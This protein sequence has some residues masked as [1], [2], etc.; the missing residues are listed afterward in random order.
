MRGFGRDCWINQQV[1]IGYHNRTDAPVLGDNVRVHAGAK[2]IGAVRVGDHAIIGA[3]AVVVKDVPADATVV[4]A[5]AR[6]VRR[7]GWR[8]GEVL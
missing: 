6:I 2:V 3:N 4:G 8:V 7:N 1:T 5:P